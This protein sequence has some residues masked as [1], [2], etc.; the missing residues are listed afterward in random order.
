MPPF[1]KHLLPVIGQLFIIYTIVFCVTLCTQFFQPARFSLIS[2]IVDESQRTQASG[3][4]QVTMNLAIIVGP[5]LAAT[6]FFTLGV[7]WALILNALSFVASFS[8]ILA[9][10]TPE[11][12]KLKQELHTSRRASRKPT[13]C[14]RAS[15]HH[16][17]HV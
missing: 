8:C 10:R 16:R 1:L 13:F 14:N 12:G 7:S 4:S 9:V 15:T 11:P 3:L 17:L 5:T 2:E 6:L